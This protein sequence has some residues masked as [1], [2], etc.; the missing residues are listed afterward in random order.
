MPG[1][2]RQRIDGGI[3]VGVGR[4]D[5]IPAAEQPQLQGNARQARIGRYLDPA[6]HLFADQQ[7]LGLEQAKA[8][9]QGK[10]PRLGPTRVT[11]DV[12]AMA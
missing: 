10:R 12:R 2:G 1:F 5:A 4:R 9:R 11:R 3:H 8:L 7:I 6:A